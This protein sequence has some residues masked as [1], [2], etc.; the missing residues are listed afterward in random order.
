[1]KVVKFAL[2]QR[3]PARDPLESEQEEIA[4]DATEP[5]ADTTV[6]QA[7]ALAP[8]GW[9]AF[10]RRRMACVGC[11][12][13]AFCTLREAAEIYNQPLPGLLAELRAAAPK[14]ARQ[15]R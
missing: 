15:A 12:M 5:T 8:R 11:Q 6:A 2:A 4:M 9:G 14:R 10:Q 13:D 3:T 7:L 1:M